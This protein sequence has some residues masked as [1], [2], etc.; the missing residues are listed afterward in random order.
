MGTVEPIVTE[1]LIL[2]RWRPE[3]R[4]AFAV[5]NADPVVMEHFIAPAGRAQSDAF[6][7]LIEAHWANRGFG[8][9]AVEVPG[10]ASFIGFTGLAVPGFQA[11]FT[12]AVEVGWR[13]ARAFWGHGYATEAARA[14]ARVAHEALGLEELVS[15]TVPA[16]VRSIAVMERLGMTRDPAGDFEHPRVPEG[17]RVRQHVLFRGRP[18]HM[19]QA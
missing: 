1:R 2:R 11:H 19:M 14:S 5:L 3:D 6:A 4:D 7:D 10:V 13:L 12:P 15:F 16:N 17:S 18:A 8:L 9:Y